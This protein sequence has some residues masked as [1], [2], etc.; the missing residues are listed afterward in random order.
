M[1][2]IEVGK[3]GIKASNIVLGCM[4]LKGK[5]PQEAEKI[6]RT[7]LKKALIILTMRMCTEVRDAEVSVRKSS[8]KQSDST[9][10]QYG[11][12]CLSRANAES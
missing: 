3:S 10:L 8:A 11:N 5:T 7:A 1:K 9:V 4:R 12:L 2:Q 6:I